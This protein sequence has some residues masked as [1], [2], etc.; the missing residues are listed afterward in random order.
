MTQVPK[1]N[2]P[3]WPLQFLLDTPLLT[4]QT[5]ARA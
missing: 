3:D 2:S 4:A 1:D 5:D